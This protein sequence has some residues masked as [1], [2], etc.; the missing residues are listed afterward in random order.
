MFCFAVLHYRRNYFRYLDRGH[1]F[2]TNYECAMHRFRPNSCYRPHDIMVLGMLNCVMIVHIS[3][4][5]EIEFKI[6]NTS[7]AHPVLNYDRFED[8]RMRNCRFLSIHVNKTT[9]GNRP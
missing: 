3:K 5:A 8:S 2:G 9:F 1:A 6:A 7:L 4:L